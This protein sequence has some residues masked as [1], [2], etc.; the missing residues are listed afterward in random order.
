M[1]YTI[2]IIFSILIFRSGFGQRTMIPDSIK[3][4]EW[5]NSLSYLP[6]AY[7]EHEYYQLTDKRLKHKF[8]KTRVIWG[9]KWYSKKIFILNNKQSVINSF[10]RFITYNSLDWISIGLSKSDKDSLISMSKKK[11][12]QGYPLY[13]CKHSDLIKYISTS[14]TIQIDINVFNTKFSKTM[15]AMTH[16]IDGVSF[17]INLSIVNMDNDTIRFE[18]NGNLYDGVKDTDVDEFLTY[19]QIYSSFKL[20]RYTPMDRY[21]TKENL[22]KII[23]RYIDYRENPMDMNEFYNTEIK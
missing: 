20:F 14:D 19:Y 7:G 22:Y 23:L 6:S 2:T 1:K 15:D 18:Y 9:L 13:S 5:I 8:S 17:C 16:V 11:N 21:F 10:D 3:S 12:F 4:F